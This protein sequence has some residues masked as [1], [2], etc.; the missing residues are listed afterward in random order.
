MSPSILPSRPEAG[1]SFAGDTIRL[2]GSLRFSGKFLLDGAFIGDIEGSGCLELGVSA[3]TEGKIVT[4]ELVHH[5]KSEGEL[6]ALNKLNL[7]AG[8]HHRGDIQ[9]SR[10]QISHQACLEGVLK[11]PDSSPDVPTNPFFGRA[12]KKILAGGLGLLV[13][14]LAAPSA[15]QRIPGYLQDFGGQIE[16][17][18]SF[19]SNQE[20][21]GGEKKIASNSALQDNLLNK[22][23]FFEKE[24]KFQEAAALLEKAVTAD[25]QK[26]VLAN[27]R[28]AKNL[29]R[30]A[31]T[32]DA[33]V[34]LDKLLLK[35]PDYIEARILLG[36][37]H[38]G[39]GNLKKA[40]LAYVEALRHDPAD[41]I[42]RRR[43]EKVR[44]RMGIGK[45]SRERA[46]KPSSP[47]AA[48]AKAEGLLKENKPVLAAKVLEKSIS[49][50][51]DEPRLYFQLGTAKTEIADRKAAI[52]A[53]E[54]VIKLAPDWLDAYVRL[55]ALLEASRRDKAAVALYKRAA[56]LDP[57]NMEMLVRIA[58][59]EKNR[60]RKDDAYRMLLK[61]KKEHPRSTEV[62]LELGML[63]WESGKAAESKE[64]FKRVLEL[65]SESAPA[66]NRLAWF[67]VVDNKNLDRG[68][69]LSKRSLEIRPDTPAYLDTLAELYY[70]NK[71]PVKSIP[72]IQRAI[73]LEPSNRYYRVQLDKFK[74]ASR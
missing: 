2:E 25:G 41:L 50:M 44:V 65:D 7:R 28:L 68:V 31:R 37:L 57:S 64:E 1:C 40:A 59:L 11:M 66:L 15:F 47:E 73:E 62:L 19:L 45:L 4:E 71:Q 49:F 6:F 34:Q 32:E 69:E 29:A 70:R 36:D 56:S 48:L 55:G 18:S 61:L 26:T 43:L 22:A 3:K 13:V 20:K 33:I 54:K 52:E 58:R 74:R 46:P 8:C 38:A 16:R 9:A 67:H 42:I 24:D 63:L 14:I 27:F 17:L 51:P 35:S 53:Y 5:G 60:G 12:R 39:S 10:V 23:L 21:T 30:L 72:L